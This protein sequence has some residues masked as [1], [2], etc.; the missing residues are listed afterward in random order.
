MQTSLQAIAKKASEQPGYR[1][2]N[3]F[4]MLDEEM[5]KDCWQFIRKDAACGVD[6]VSAK[7][8]EQNLDENIHQLVEDLKRKRYRAKHILRRYIPKGNG[9]FRPLG[10]PATQ[11]KLLQVAVKR[12]L[13]AI[14]EQDF[15]PSSYGYRPGIGALDAV[16]KLNVKLQFGKYNYV[17][18]A[19]IKGFFDNLDHDWLLKML[20]ERV[21]DKALLWLIGKWL[22]AGVLDTDGKTLHP[23]T[24]TPQGG[25]ISPILAN[26]YLHFALDLWF[27]KVVIP[28]CHGEA[29]LMRFADDFVCV[30]EKEED[31]Q[32]FFDVLGKRLG[33]F[34]LELSAEKTQIIPFSPIISPGKTA[35]DFLGFEFRW[36]KDRRGRPHVKKRTARKSLRNSK[37]RFT[38]WCRDNR[39]R[40]LPDLF[41]ALNAK[42]R[43]YYNYFGVHGNSLSLNAFYL[44][45]V[46]TLMKFLNRRSQRKSYNWVGFKQLMEQF[47]IAKPHI[48]GRPKRALAKVALGL[49]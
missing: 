15:L 24:G 3:L 2:R 41:K 48:V 7:E 13:E 18:E 45:A 22:K 19:D 14:F 26:V 11:D 20:A 37:K 9:K 35:F 21:D 10:I 28:L 46:R 29:F 31:A 1:F 42:L 30:F 8:Y 49:A 40:R 34:G 25:I 39:H 5:L 6:R 4:G 17:V 38:Q 43:G 33:K 16:D 47:G 32:R 12:L 23:E 44:H 27:Q 36:G